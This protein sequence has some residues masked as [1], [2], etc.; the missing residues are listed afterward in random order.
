MIIIEASKTL[1][2][3][4]KFSWARQKIP[5]KFIENLDTRPQKGSPAIN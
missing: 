4:S 3:S 5:L 1:F 2:C